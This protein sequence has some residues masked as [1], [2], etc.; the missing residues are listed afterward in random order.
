MSQNVL[1]VGAVGRS[2]SRRCVYTVSILLLSGACMVASKICNGIS[3]QNT[4]LQSQGEPCMVLL[5][6]QGL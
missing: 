4:A 3:S 2:L 1:H 6:S 5:F